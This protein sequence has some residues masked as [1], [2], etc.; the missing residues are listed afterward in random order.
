MGGIDNLEEARI[1]DKVLIS[2][3]R[4]DSKEYVMHGSNLSGVIDLIKREPDKFNKDLIKLQKK[5][6]IMLQ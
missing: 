6:S 5:K 1:L 4:G 2:N 3:D